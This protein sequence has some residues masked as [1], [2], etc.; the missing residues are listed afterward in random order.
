MTIRNAKLL[1]LG[2][3]LVIAA[4]WYFIVYPIVC[5]LE[6]WCGQ[7]NATTIII[8]LA[9]AAALIAWMYTWDWG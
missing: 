9:V 4:S 2:L 7:M 5:F 1:A 6:P 8:S 3:I